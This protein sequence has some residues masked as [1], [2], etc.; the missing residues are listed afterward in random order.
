MRA[1]LKC[2]ARMD[3]SS[4][5]SRATKAH[6][7]AHLMSVRRSVLD[8]LTR[9]RLQEVALK[10]GISFYSNATR[11]EII[12]GIARSL[13]VSLKELLVQFLRDELKLACQRLELDERGHQRRELFKRIIAFD[14]RSRKKRA[15]SKAVAKARARSALSS[16][17]RGTST[18]LNGVA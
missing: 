2:S 13:G 9:P 5:P 15:V 3:L 16:R 11:D 17:S 8:V 14:R 18:F 6:D 10:V 1:T 7:P 12:N 4:S